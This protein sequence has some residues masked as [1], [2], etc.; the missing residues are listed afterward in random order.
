MSSADNKS[1]VVGSQSASDTT[2]TDEAAED[3]PPAE[4]EATATD[5]GTA[6]AREEEGT[7]RGTT[8]SQPDTGSQNEKYFRGVTQT[9]CFPAPPR[10]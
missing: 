1:V 4:A 10:S 5:E 7:G 2:A 9:L 6:T 8:R 3:V